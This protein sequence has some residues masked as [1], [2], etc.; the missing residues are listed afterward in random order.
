M[1]NKTDFLWKLV[2]IYQFGWLS[3]LH[4]TMTTVPENKLMLYF[5]RKIFI[6]YYFVNIYQ[7]HIFKIIVVKQNNCS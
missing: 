3:W 7:Q 5:R 2:E 6:A 1:G 4:N